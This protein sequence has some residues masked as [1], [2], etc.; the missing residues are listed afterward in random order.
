MVASVEAIHI[1][2]V[3]DEPILRSSLR[4]SLEAAGYAVSEAGNKAEVLR[5]LD[6][7]AAVHLLTLDLR[8]GNEDGL[9][10]AQ[11]IRAKRNIPII[12]IT[13]SG[14]PVDRLRGLE[15]GADDY[16]VKPFQMREVLLR[17]QSTLR[18]YE[19]EAVANSAA[20]SASAARGAKYRC[21]L[22]H[23]DVAQRRF[24][25]LSGAEVDLTD[26]E[27]DIL[28]IF[29]SNP[30]RILSRDDISLH[31]RGRLWSPMDRTIDGHIARLRKKVEVDPAR[32]V[33]KTVWGV[34]YV[35]SDDVEKLGDG[36]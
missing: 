28:N 33:I 8:L 4:Q 6:Q 23:V 19:L 13:A 22:G 24:M 1:L 29:M 25:N 11:E 12:M 14:T 5:R 35:F 36:S 34:G 2:I 26:M 15:H 17:V 3:E 7:N 16:I 27:F 20:N 9:A 31:L 30:S 10:L 21:I 32:P 18:R